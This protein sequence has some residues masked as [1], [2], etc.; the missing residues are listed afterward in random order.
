MDQKM[1]RSGYFGRVRLQSGRGR[2]HQFVQKALNE[3]NGV[4]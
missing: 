4:G 2:D 3:L 1:L